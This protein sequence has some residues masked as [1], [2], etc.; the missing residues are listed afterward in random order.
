MIQTIFG[1]TVVF[2]KTDKVES[3]FPT[4]LYEET[5]NYLLDP[6]NNFIDHP[7]ARNGK[8]YTTAQT[9]NPEK[10]EDIVRCAPLLD[11]L[12]TNALNYAHL[13]SAK[14]VQDIKFHA[15]WC[16]LTYKGCE[17]SCHRDNICSPEK[18]LIV[19]FY[20]KIP[21]NSSN[22]VFVRNGKD[23]DWPTDRPDEDLVC[24]RVTEGDIIMID[25]FIWHAVDPHNSDLPR[26]CIAVEFKIET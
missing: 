10:W 5:V 15:S 11:F 25:S 2:L 13:Y 3:L 17:I 23:G 16:N 8:I 21:N 12:K 4:N 26:M 18:S 14:P 6:N 22:L 7:Q 19:L 9:L 1:S 20:V 24:L